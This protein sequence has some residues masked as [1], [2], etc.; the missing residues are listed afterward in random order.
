[1][2]ILSP[3]NCPSC[4]SKLTQINSQ[5]FCT[6]K[7]DCPAQSTKRLQHFCKVLKIKGFGEK[8]VEKLEISKFSDLLT[9]TAEYCTGK[10]IGAKVAINLTTEVESK[11]K[12]KIPVREF[13]AGMSIP[14]VGATLA[15]KLA[16][17]HPDNYSYEVLRELGAGDKAASELMEW[18]TTE[19]TQ[20]LKPLWNDYLTVEDTIKAKTERGDV[21]ITGKLT[22][23]SN[24]TEAAKYLASLGWTVKN[25]VTKTVQYLICEDDTKVNSSS[26]KKAKANGIE[27]LTIKDL[28]DK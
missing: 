23:F 6:N 11:L 5:L 19:W 26:Y 15:S 18:Q 1:M 28:E 27:I 24:R 9:L 21:C 22:D 25:S 10:G 20:Y 3:T 13:I 12:R 17:L 7:I 4:G 2:E 16:G 14:L 8:T